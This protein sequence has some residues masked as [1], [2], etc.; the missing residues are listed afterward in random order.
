MAI[1]QDK[2]VDKR[3]LD[4]GQIGYIIILELQVQR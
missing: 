3:F 1:G 2:S 4:K